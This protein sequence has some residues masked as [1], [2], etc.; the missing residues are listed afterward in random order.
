MTEHIIICGAGIAGLS[1]AMALSHADRTITVIDRDPPPPDLGPD[2]AFESWERKGVTQL[3]HSHVFLGRLIKLI[4]ERHPGLWTALLAAGAR[5]FTFA[6]GLS[7][8]LRGRY[9]YVAGDEDLS[10]LFSRRTTLELAM[11][12]YAATLPG[13]TFLTNAGLH[14]A[15][16]ENGTI[17][18][19]VAE[20]DGV[21]QEIRADSIVDATGRNT[22]FP[23]WMGLEG[24]IADTIPAGILYFTRHYRLLDGAE[25]PA[26]D[27][28]S[29]AGDLGYIKFG[30]FPADNRHFSI[31]LAVPEIETGLRAA[32]LGPEIFDATCRAI[33]GTARWIDPAR[34]EPA[35]KVFGMGNL[36]SVWRRYAPEGT[37]RVRRYYPIGDAALRTNP[38]YGRGCSTGAIQAHLLADIFAETD[39]ATA[40]LVALEQRTLSELRPFY[41]VMVQQDKQA[42]RRAAQELTPGYK[43]RLKARMTK[44]FL[45]D[46]VGPASRSD[47]EVLRAVMRPFHM[48]ENP[49]A[50]TKRAPIMARV[51]KMWATPKALKKRHYLPKPGPE[52]AEMLATLGLAA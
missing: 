43:P 1:A 46:A 42:I 16:V 3:R 40:R 31:T 51:L 30:V 15:I 18:G 17:L 10:F 2:E 26:R 24:T 32:M 14:G 36:H 12:R 6:D 21:R 41:D 25:E 48:L 28:P 8:L 45:E 47:I 20:I 23:E 7:P 34:A 27:G 4:R 33:P 11:R 22:S 50:W 5:E 19:V 9:R 29:G 38:L 44:S 52:R 37:P 39:D 13:V 35:S 49:T